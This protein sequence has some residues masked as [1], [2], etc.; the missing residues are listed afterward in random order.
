MRLRIYIL[1]IV[2]L[3]L[4]SCAEDLS[5]PKGE[6]S[7]Y[8]TV[9]NSAMSTKV[10]APGTLNE[11]LISRLDIFLYPKGKT[12]ESPV[13]Y[14]TMSGL[15][16]DGT[17]TVP[18]YVPEDVVNMLFPDSETECEVFA[19]ANL[20]QS[21][22]LSG[23][24][25]VG[26]LQGISVSSEAFSDVVAADGSFDAP[27]DFLMSGSCMA[28]RNGDSIGG[29]VPLKRAAAKV[30]MHVTIPEYLDV[31][32]VDQ[33]GNAIID[34]VTGRQKVERW[35]PYF[36]GT[37]ENGIQMMHMGFHK[38]LGK[39]FVEGINAREENDVFETLYTEEFDYVSTSTIRI[40]SLDIDKDYHLYECEVSFYSYALSWE[41][42]DNDVEAPY[43]TLMVPWKR[44][45]DERFQTYYYQVIVNGRSQKIERNKW[46]DMKLNVGVLGSRVYNI[47]TELDDMSCYVL[48]WSDG[49]M[50][51]EEDVN[52]HEWHYLVVPEHRIEMNNVEVGSLVFDASH[53]IGWTLEWPGSMDGLDALEKYNADRSNPYSAYYINCSGKTPAAQALS[54]ITD[55]SFAVSSDDETLEFTH[56]IPENVNSPIYVHLKIWLDINGNGIMDYDESSFVEHVTFVQYPPIYIIP[57]QSTAHSIFVNGINSRDSGSSDS[58]DIKYNGNAYNLG[59]IPGTS[60]SGDHMYTINV[61]SFNA[62]DVFECEG[63]HYQYLIGDPR[64]EDSD[65]NL[66]DDGYDMTRHWAT[67][68]DVDGDTRQIRYYYPTASQGDVFRV[69]AP[70]FRVVSFLSSGHSKITP[71]G[72][73]MRCASFQEDGFPAGRWR[74]PTFAEISFVISL[75]QKGL[76][77][78]IFYGTNYY[79]SSTHQVQN[80][81]GVINYRRIQDG[82]V[83][84]V[85]CVYDEWYWGSER[86]AQPDASFDGGYAFT[87]GDEER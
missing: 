27:E 85:R 44:M 46:Y 5:G 32:V 17:V 59:R 33:E 86:E 30:T 79:Y 2:T 42:K 63:S 78:N 22:S 55:A 70:K 61:S 81:N 16:A 7:L 20:P 11:R 14:K 83:G 23:D 58:D 75:Q 76:I 3:A 1:M 87:W 82:Y 15:Q 53:K 9:F 57:D 45:E 4:C 72:A 64:M 31:K 10:D 12:D 26:D 29:V 80:N 49:L 28:V 13:F 35:Y 37:A 65:L 73:A 19:V 34:P 77:Q 21:I 6:H 47:P 66:N 18:L 67:A 71:E 52:I 24:E 50:G 39:T 84:S 54:E 25:T 38:G 74:L 48:D 60:D 40:D 62:D 68:K 56:V 51:I 8:L 36:D 69:I 43:F 41:G